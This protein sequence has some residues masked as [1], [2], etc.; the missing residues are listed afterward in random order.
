MR[1]LIVDD[2]PVDSRLLHAA[3]SGWGHSCELAC[4]GL[5]ATKLTD[6]E[7]FD[8]VLMDGEMPVMNGV[9]AVRVMRSQDRN[10]RRFTPII[11][12][13]ADEQ[14]DSMV[15][16]LAAGAD[17]YLTKPVDWSVLSA[18][19]KVFERI[20]SQHRELQLYREHTEDSQHFGREVLEALNRINTFDGAVH[21]SQRSKDVLSGDLFAATQSNDGARYALLAD[22]MGHG[23]PAALSTVLLADLFYAMAHRARPLREIAAEANAKLKRLLPGGFFVAAALARVEPNVRRLEVW[24]CAMP[25]V[26]FR[27]ESGSVHEFKSHSPALAVMSAAEFDVTGHEFIAT[28]PGELLL[29]SDGFTEAGPHTGASAS[30][31]AELASQLERLVLHDDATVASIRV[32]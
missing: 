25:T 30:S 26:Y 18:K 31:Y 10:A 32:I 9:D 7:A 17:D 11:F 27:G 13:S 12:V 29:V 2:S 6:S 21:V 5:A 1:I 8:L 16:G 15:A 28:E 22:G 20:A 4:N 14:S 23:L 19:L 3:L 24:N